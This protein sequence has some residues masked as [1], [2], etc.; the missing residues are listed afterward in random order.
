MQAFGTSQLLQPGV[1]HS[2]F[3]RHRGGPALSQTPW[4]LTPLCFSSQSVPWTR[5]QATYPA[6]S[7]IR[8]PFTFQVLF[9]C[10]LPSDDSPSLSRMSCAPL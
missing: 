3:P 9:I 2:L 10:S 5:A 7:P 6:A 4:T 1:L 8:P